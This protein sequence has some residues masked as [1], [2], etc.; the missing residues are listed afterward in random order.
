MTINL[1]IRQNQHVAEDKG[2]E[3]KKDM[4]VVVQM[5][6]DC[7]QINISKLLKDQHSMHKISLKVHQMRSMYRSKCGKSPFQ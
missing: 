4:Y 7:E 3:E 2:P 5:L 1:A 6:Y